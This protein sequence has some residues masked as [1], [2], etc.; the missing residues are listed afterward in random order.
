VI[1]LQNSFQ[2]L[3]IVVSGLLIILTIIGFFIDDLNSRVIRQKKNQIANAIKR[4]SNTNI[5]FDLIDKKTK[6]VKKYKIKKYLE[7]AGLDYTYNQ[8]AVFRISLMVSLFLITMFLMNSPII[9]LIISL[10]SGFIPTQVVMVMKNTRYERLE[11]Q[12]EPFFKMVLSRYENS[13]DI[14][15]SLKTTEYDFIGENPMH[16]EI[17]KTNMDIRLGTP[18]KEALMSMAKRTSNPFLERFAEYYEVSL[19]IGNSRDRHAILNQAYA[20]FKEFR[21]LKMI[22][23]KELASPKR[24]AYIMLATIPVFFLYQASTNDEYLDFMFKTLIGQVGT[25]IILMIVL[26]SIW[27]INNKINAPLE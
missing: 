15:E 19:L 1:T 21:E 18:V 3:I 9:A 8:F 24:D 14:V 6:G 23:K 2:A 26:G 13:E 27:F 16:S 22:V 12:F 4:T 25:S 11:E 10:F 17:K 5:I 7:Q 20:Q